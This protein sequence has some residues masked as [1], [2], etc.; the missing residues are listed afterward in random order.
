MI[1]WLT[2]RQRERCQRA[3][4]LLPVVRI[5]D[6]WGKNGNRSLANMGHKC[7]G[8]YYLNKANTADCMSRAH[9][10]FIQ[11]YWLSSGRATALNYTLDK[12]NLFWPIPNSA[13]TANN[14][15]QL[16]QNYGYDGY[17]ASVPMFDNWEDA[18]EDEY[19]RGTVLLL[20]DSLTKEPSP[21]YTCFLLHCSI[22]L[23]L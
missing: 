18:V 7:T 20:A 14:K 12:R 15:A 5:P 6:S 17:D 22:L 11:S 8:T 4:Q 2:L 19:N 3:Y 13:I 21:C 16:A 1:L 9:N 10:Q 23:T